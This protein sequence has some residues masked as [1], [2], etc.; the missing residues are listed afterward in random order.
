[1]DIQSEKITGVSTAFANVYRITT[2]NAILD[3]YCDV[4]E[5]APKVGDS[6]K[7]RFMNNNLANNA[8]NN[9]TT[10]SPIYG[11]I[12]NGI[13]FKKNETAK[14]HVSFGGFLGLFD[15]QEQLGNFNIGDKICMWYQLE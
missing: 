2:D 11:T 7:Y 15:F 14:I 1:M 6:L 3:T 9:L 4:G 13:I 5:K 8:A 12:M 10:N